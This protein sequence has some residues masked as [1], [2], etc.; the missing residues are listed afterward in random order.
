[1]KNTFGERMLLKN[2]N[3]KYLFGS[4]WNFGKPEL[5]IIKKLETPHSKQTK[6][7]S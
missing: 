1:M 7:F 3:I 4:Y 6:G 5:Y 2:Y